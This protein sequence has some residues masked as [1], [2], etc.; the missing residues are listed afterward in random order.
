MAKKYLDDEGNFDFTVYKHEVK[1]KKKSK[2]RKKGESILSRDTEKSIHEICEM[3][4]KTLDSK[5]KLKKDANKALKRIEAYNLEVFEDKKNSGGISRR[6][7]N[8]E[9]KAYFNEMEEIR[10]R[11]KIANDADNSGLLYKIAKILKVAGPIAKMIAKAVASF[12]T[13][14]LGIEGVSNKLKPKTLDKLV[15]VFNL[16]MA[17]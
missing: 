15:G 4:E 14:I 10:K 1:V 13:M 2:N 7:V 12:V 6:K 17:V 11:V 16:A 3:S 8:K 5:K 9:A